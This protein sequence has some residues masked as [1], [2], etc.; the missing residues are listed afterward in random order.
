[1]RSQRPAPGRRKDRRGRGVAAEIPARTEGSRFVAI[2]PCREPMGPERSRMDRGKVS[3]SRHACATREAHSSSNGAYSSP[4]HVRHPL[5]GSVSAPGLPLGR[6]WS[7]PVS[8]GNASPPAS[9]EVEFA[10]GRMRLEK[11][12]S[13]ERAVPGRTALLPRP[14]DRCSSTVAVR[15]LQFDRQWSD[16][17]ERPKGATQGSDPVE[18]CSAATR[19][20]EC[21][22]QIS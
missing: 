9:A 7:T 16:P 6:R 18:P 22:G 10:T 11:E 1:L 20:T 13:Q 12:S 17:R 3:H 14:S 4:T 21:V 19:A 8:P 2:V 15:P 5:H